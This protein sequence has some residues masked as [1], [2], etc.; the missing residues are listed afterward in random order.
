MPKKLVDTKDLVNI[1]EL[2]NSQIL[3]IIA[4]ANEFKAGSQTTLPKAERFATNM[5]FENSTRTHNSFH[6]AET[7]L[8]INIIEFNASESSIEK[9]ESLYDT[10]LA[11][12]AIGVDLCVI[13]H[14]DNNYY[15]QLINQKSITASIVNAGDGNGE[16][17]SQCLLDLMTIKEEFTNFTNLKVA[18]VGDISHSRVAVSDAKA[19]KSLGCEIYFS[20]PPIWYNSKFEAYGKYKTLDELVPNMDIII[21]L[22][23]QHERHKTE[24]K[25]SKTKYHKTFGLTTQ[26]ARKMKNSAIIMHPA[27][28]NRNVE[29]ADELIESKQSRIVQQM[30]N[31]VFT[32][33]AIIENVLKNKELHDL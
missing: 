29:L 31:G 18:I 9:G 7:K 24:T 5:F 19:L 10:V 1:D 8:G 22:R 25:F 14:Q 26:R 33:M 2:T 4:R 16:H 27:P 15:N 23:V 28:V 11:L 3:Q 6:I 13:R 30:S 21:M 17:P 20:G 12:C 32:R